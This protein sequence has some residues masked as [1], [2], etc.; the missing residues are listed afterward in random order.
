MGPL[1][2]RYWEEDNFWE[3]WTYPTPVELVGAR[4]DGE[5]V[6]PG[7]SLDLQQLRSAFESVAA[8]GWKALGFND[9][10]GPHVFV[11]GVFQGRGVYLQVLAQAP[12]DEEPGLK[13]DTTKRP[14]GQE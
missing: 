12:E 7:F 4:H 9:A 3:I 11:E 6:V 8:F 13:V 5:V 14:R 1:G 10:E 2:L